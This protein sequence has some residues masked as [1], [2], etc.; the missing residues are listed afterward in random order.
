MTTLYLYYF[1]FSCAACEPDFEWY[2]ISVVSVL[3]K[4]VFSKYHQKE[5]SESEEFDEA[6]DDVDFDLDLELEDDERKKQ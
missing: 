1:Q 3:E 6:I 2:H 4:T 5:K